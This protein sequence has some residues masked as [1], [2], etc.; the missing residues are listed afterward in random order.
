MIIKPIQNFLAAD[1]GITAQLSTYQ[2]SSGVDSPA[3]FVGDIPDDATFRCLLIEA[4]PGTPWGCRGYRGS[5]ALTDISVLEDKERSEKAVKDLAYDV[6]R[7]MDRAQFSLT[8]YEL[9]ACWANSPGRIEVQDGF[10]G[11]LIQVR[12]LVL[13]VADSK[14]SIVS[15]HSVLV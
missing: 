1:A 13:E 7:K 3:I 12:T 15:L 6:W 10:P 9:V 11:F 5:E 8:G 4:L 2:F 14:L